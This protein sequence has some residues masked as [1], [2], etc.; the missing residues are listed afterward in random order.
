[1]RVRIS[2]ADADYNFAVSF[3]SGIRLPANCSYWDYRNEGVERLLV[4]YR[5]S[6]ETQTILYDED[7]ELYMR[8]H[9][10]SIQLADKR[11]LSRSEEFETT[12]EQLD[13]SELD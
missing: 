13:E 1:M 9:V 7:K 5:P 8:W 10:T 3:S 4:D 6:Q 2:E 12:T 11:V